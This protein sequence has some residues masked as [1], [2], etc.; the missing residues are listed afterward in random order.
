MKKNNALKWQK[1]G[2]AV[3]DQKEKLLKK[4]IDRQRA[5]VK[6][7]SQFSPPQ[8]APLPPDFCFSGEIT[9]QQTP[10]SLTHFLKQLNQPN[11]FTETNAFITS[12]QDTKWDSS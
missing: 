2:L 6:F 11:F 4:K 12:H 5:G 9:L 8:E 3:R 7:N 1:T 10:P